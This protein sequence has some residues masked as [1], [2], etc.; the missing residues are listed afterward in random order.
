[1]NWVVCGLGSGPQSAFLH[2]NRKWR[3]RGADEILPARELISLIHI[4]HKAS[5]QRAA[6]PNENIWPGHYIQLQ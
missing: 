1:M 4:K 6:K 2:E 3:K 5:E